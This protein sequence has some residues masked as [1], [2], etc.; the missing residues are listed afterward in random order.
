MTARRLEAGQRADGVIVF[1]RPSFKES[2]EKLQLQLAQA[3]Q[4]DRP[5]LLPVPFTASSRAGEKPAALKGPP[6]AVRFRSMALFCQRNDRQT[7]RLRMTESVLLLSLKHPTE[8]RTR[9]SRPEKP[10]AISILIPT[11]RRPSKRHGPRRREILLQELQDIPRLNQEHNR[12]QAAWPGCIQILPLPSDETEASARCLKHPRL[13]VALL[14]WAARVNV[15]R[16]CLGER[17]Q[18][19]ALA[20]GVAHG[21]GHK[22]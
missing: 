16:I 1:E 21:N 8:K 17:N 5:I 7:L 13:C 20:E 6:A 19:R 4:V 15:A 3:E 11:V 9:A 14:A 22:A 12:C 18:N 10:L 2:S